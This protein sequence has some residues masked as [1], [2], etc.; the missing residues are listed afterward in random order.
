[1]KN[2]FFVIIFSFFTINYAYPDS[3]SDEIIDCTQFQKIKDKL[4][5]KAKNLKTTLN[6]NQTKDQE[7]TTS[8]EEVKV[9]VAETS[10]KQSATKESVS[11]K[12]KEKKETKD[13]PK[14][15]TKTKKQ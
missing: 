9:E 11:K 8:E 5:C 15:K 3:H 13:S 1:M 10:V 12:S 7:E 2:I 4:D 14:N 6:K